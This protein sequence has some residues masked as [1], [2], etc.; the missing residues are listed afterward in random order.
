MPPPARSEASPRAAVNGDAREQLL[1]EQMAE[2]EADYNDVK[3]SELAA[4]NEVG[5]MRQQVESRD[6]ELRKLKLHILQLSD[7]IDT[8]ALHAEEEKHD[9]R[10]QIESESRSYRSRNHNMN[11]LVAQLR[12]DALDA[13]VRHDELKDEHAASLSAK[14]RMHEEILRLEKA[15][16]EHEVRAN[17]AEVK[18]SDMVHQRGLWETAEK[19]W[20]QRVERAELLVLEMEKDTATLSRD[21]EVLRAEKDGLQLVVEEQRLDLLQHQ[22][23]E[24]DVR[25]ALAEASSSAELL[26]T[27]RRE[28]EELLA[29]EAEHQSLINELKI[30]KQ[31][32]MVH[33][34]GGIRERQAVIDSL[35]HGNVRSGNTQ[36]QLK[37]IE[38]EALK[39]ELASIVQRSEEEQATTQEYVSVLKAK[40]DSSEEKLHAVCTPYPPLPTAN[41]PIRNYSLVITGLGA[42]NRNFPAKIY[43][44][45]KGLPL[46]QCFYPTNVCWT[47][48]IDFIPTTTTT[49][50]S[51]KTTAVCVQSSSSQRAKSTTSTPK[52][53]GPP[54]SRTNS[55]RRLTSSQPSAAPSRSAVTA[56]NSP[57]KKR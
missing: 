9:L 46:I 55:R 13:K 54:H 45:E 41:I 39:T 53:T 7:Y 51:E 19:S 33:L 36:M 37:I 14:E 6:E 32:M 56:K 11:Q 57:C 30:E 31:K 18:C 12:Q 50:S 29:R 5:A 1:R 43:G 22:R 44:G 3:S 8:S 15:Y 35:T 38:A 48:V 10:K 49:H 34:Q 23:K 40:A 17:T 24:G 42:E 16:S 52:E 27:T 25:S 28:N 2:L 21:N 4:R 26:V 47:A 20:V